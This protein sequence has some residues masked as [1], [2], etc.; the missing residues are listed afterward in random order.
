MF[1]WPLELLAVNDFELF[2]SL[3]LET[4]QDVR[5]GSK[6]KDLWNLINISDK[7]SIQ[8]HTETMRVLLP[9]FCY[10]RR[11]AKPRRR[12]KK[13]PVTKRLIVPVC[14]IKHDLFIFVIEYFFI[15]EMR[16]YCIMGRG[17]KV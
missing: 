6:R 16:R 9:G 12:G 2:E 15:E 7:C 5:I 1:T 17:K 13:T 11:L 4:V 8:V 10:T 14:K 3:N